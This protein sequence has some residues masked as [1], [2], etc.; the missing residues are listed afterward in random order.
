MDR[1]YGGT[2][3]GP[4]DFLHAERAR[5][6]SSGTVG[7]GT[8][9]SVGDHGMYPAADLHQG[10]F[11]WRILCIFRPGTGRVDGDGGVR[12]VCLTRRKKVFERRFAWRASCWTNRYQSETSGVECVVGGRE[13][14]TWRIAAS[15]HPVIL[16]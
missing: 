10:E 15:I 11:L 4:G 9:G 6:R 3:S 13:A 12:S 2:P 5:E 7:G 8:S 16:L 1:R 14:L